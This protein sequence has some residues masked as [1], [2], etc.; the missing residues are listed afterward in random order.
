[1]DHL[2]CILPTRFFDQ[3]RDIPF[4]QYQT[5]MSPGR[6]AGAAMLEALAKI[7]P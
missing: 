3:T 7:I 6:E 5:S 2:G 4:A 1:L